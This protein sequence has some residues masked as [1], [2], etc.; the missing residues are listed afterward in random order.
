MFHKERSEKIKETNNPYIDARINYRSNEEKEKSNTRMW[1]IASLSALFIVAILA[2]GYVAEKKESKFIPYIVEVNQLG[3]SMTSKIAQRAIPTDPRII[4]ATLAEFISN[5]RLVTPDSELQKR[6]IRKVYYHLLDNTPGIKQTNEFFS[7]DKSNPFHR[8]EKVI[9]NC[10]ILSVLPQTKK[11]WQV[12]W[13]EHV[14]SHNG[15]DLG[16]TRR[17]GIIQVIVKE[18]TN[19]TTEDEIRRNPLGIFIQSYALSEEIQ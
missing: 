3:Q 13:L 15:D 4:K 10:E 9:V 7:D 5:L 17:T 8:A 12:T 11:S 16:T 6:A 18:N 2:G 1:Q 19:D 14:R